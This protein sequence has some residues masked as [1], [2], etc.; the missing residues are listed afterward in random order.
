MVWGHYQIPS[1]TFAGSY[2]LGLWSVVEGGAWKV[3]PILGLCSTTCNNALV[4]YQPLSFIFLKFPF[5]LIFDWSE[6]DMGL[7]E[8]EN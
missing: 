4:Y 1:A 8:N 7:T 2:S 6:K 5:F 3:G